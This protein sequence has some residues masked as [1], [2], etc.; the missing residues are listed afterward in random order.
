MN[1]D[2]AYQMEELLDKL[3]IVDFIEMLESICYEKEEHLKTNWQD[4]TIAKLW[5][6]NAKA[7]E[8]L[9]VYD[10]F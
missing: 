10:T 5:H 4:S 2:K 6:R 1:E 7:L 3:G 8:N 9:K